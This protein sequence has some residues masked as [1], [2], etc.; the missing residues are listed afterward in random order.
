MHELIDEGTASTQFQH[1]HLKIL[2]S[3]L[4][5][6]IQNHQEELICLLSIISKKLLTLQIACCTLCS[7]FLRAFVSFEI[8][9]QYLIFIILVF[10]F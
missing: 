9:D 6:Y 1:N 2:S 10:P 7:E 3:N 5:S 8:V 4:S